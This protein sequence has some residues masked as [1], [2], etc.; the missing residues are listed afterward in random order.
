[1]QCNICNILRATAHCK[2]NQQD[3]VDQICNAHSLAWESQSKL[4]EAHVQ[5][6]DK[7][8]KTKRKAN[9]ECCTP[10]KRR[11]SLPV[12]PVPSIPALSP[13][14]RRVRE[15]SP[16]S[17]NSLEDSETLP[18]NWKHRV[19]LSL[20]ALKEQEE[21]IINDVN[22]AKVLSI[23]Q[24]QLLAQDD[25]ISMTET[26]KF[27]AVHSCLL[28]SEQRPHAYRNAISE[29]N[30]KKLRQGFEHRQMSG[31]CPRAVAELLPVVRNMVQAKVNDEPWLPAMPK[32]LTKASEARHKCLCRLSEVTCYALKKNWEPDWVE[33]NV[34]A[35]LP[36][37]RDRG[38]EATI[39]SPTEYD[40]RRPDVFIK[41]APSVCATERALASW[42][43]KSPFASKVEQGGKG[44]RFGKSDNVYKIAVY[45]PGESGTVYEVYLFPKV[46]LAVEVGRIS[47]PTV[48]SMGQDMKIV[49]S[50]F[51][52]EELFLRIRHLKMD[53]LWETLEM[54]QEDLLPPTPKKKAKGKEVA[55]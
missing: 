44:E 36:L 23:Y 33:K 42:E 7:V 9:D 18:N 12:P 8:A 39:D 28:V 47:V 2:L 35:F 19:H 25:E 17:V 40:L 51:E 48:L 50:I 55:A 32:R 46:F 21:V 30:W 3:H 26:E 31:P 41:L 49:A 1:M 14:Q 13:S 24:R 20:S 37:L 54:T 11:G 15:T 22:V 43:I 52:M 6:L 34:G 10:T 38:L 5:I 45:L 53:M 4:A 16:S 29:T 27:L